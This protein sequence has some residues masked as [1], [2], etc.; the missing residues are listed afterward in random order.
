MSM[1]EAIICWSLSLSPSLSLS[2]CEEWKKKKQNNCSIEQKKRTHKNSV[3]RWNRTNSERKQ[4][5]FFLHRSKNYLRN[6]LCDF[7]GRT[8][9]NGTNES[10]KCDLRSCN[11]AIEYRFKSSVADRSSLF[12]SLQ[13]N[14]LFKSA[15]PMQ[16][17]SDI[18]HFGCW[19]LRILIA[20]AFDRFGNWSLRLSNASTIDHFSYRSPH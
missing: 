6:S 5:I 10:W 12:C 20:L 13:S 18:D 2:L 7:D 17:T 1:C 4:T 16:I 11:V 14:Q 3:C 15:L 8:F 9:E 19:S